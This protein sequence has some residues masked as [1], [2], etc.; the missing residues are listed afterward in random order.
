MTGKDINNLI[1][2][3]A[4]LAGVYFVTSAIFGAKKR[5]LDQPE[6]IEGVGA[7]K[8]KRRIWFEVQRAQEAGV[9]LT[10]P[11]GWKGKETFLRK[12]SQGKLSRSSSSKSDEERYF[13]QLRRAYNS[14]A[15]TSIIPDQAVIRNQYGDVILTYNDYHL[16]QLP[17]IAADWMEKESKENAASPYA[18]GYWATVAAIAR[19]K[20]FIWKGTKDGIHRGIEELVFGKAAPSERKQRISYL[21][22]K[23]KGGVYPE[24]WAHSLW[25]ANDSQ[26]DDQEITNGVLDALRD[27]PSVGAAQQACADAF[28]QAHQVQEP[29]LYEGIPF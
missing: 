14:I 15:G 3:G 18:Y 21:A 29:L 19:G 13:G 4:I 9:D 28:M 25:E 7:T 27:T 6:D 10:D 22:S 26:Q 11:N 2:T 24:K 8:A 12:A 16:D 1:E 23:E 17:Q 5:K 20:R